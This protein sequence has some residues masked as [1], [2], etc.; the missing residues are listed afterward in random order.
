MS[1][2]SRLTTTP[3][4][5]NLVRGALDLERTAHGL[6]PHR[7][8]ARARAQNTDG[9]LA[10]AEAQ[11][12][13]VRIALRTRAT[14]V[15]LD[16]LPTK[17]VYVG[18][19][20]RPD[21]VYD[22]LVD[23]HQAGRASVE[24][25]NVLTIDL[26]TGS[27]VTRPGPVGTVRFDGLPARPKDVEIWLPHNETTELVALRTDAPVEPVPNRGRAV[28]LHHGSSISHG[29]DAASPT[30]TWPALAAAL[31]GVELVNLG[32]GGSAL[33]DPFTAR[34]LRDT[35]A[36]LISVKAGINLVNTDV[37]RLRA[38]TPAVHGFLDTIRDGHPT[39]PL[40][41]VSPLLCPIHEDTP[42]PSAPDRSAMSEGRLS[43]RAAGDPAET[44]GGKLTLRTIRRELARIVEQRAAE[45][46][47]LHY[48]DGRELYGEADSAEL[49]LPDALH[50][51]AATHRR[52]GERFARL[53]FGAG[54]PLAGDAPRP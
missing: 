7:L 17:R 51:D 36:D 41:V 27:A 52:I 9:Q 48:L 30:T 47:N 37:M 5:E 2:H 16:T 20:P 39:I 33:L 53:A 45:D 50:P 42:G 4:T 21:G 54:G 40:L 8:P 43:F 38:F 29:S 35:P 32:Y 24:G 6:L 44:A 25:G 49:P 31:G 1:P 26:A 11:P 12:S 3:L 22:L 28:W 15:E 19:P 13:G 14:V 23:G 18:A 34:T 46:P 10:M